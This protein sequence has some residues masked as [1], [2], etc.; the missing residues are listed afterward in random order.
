MPAIPNLPD[1][2]LEAMKREIEKRVNNQEPRDYLGASLIGNPCSRQIWYTIHHCEREPFT[3]DTLMKF[4]DGHRTEDLTAERL[5]MVDGLELWTHDEEGKQFGFVAMDGKFKGHVDGIIRGLLQAPSALHVW[6]AKACE[7]KKYNEFIKCKATY[8]EKNALKAWN[9]NYYV[10]AQIN[11]HYFQIDRH[12]LTV[13]RAGG[14]GYESC[15]TEYDGEF[16]ERFINRA[17]AIL[18]ANEPPPRISEKPE[19]Y[20]CNWCEFKGVCR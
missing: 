15:R 10:Q 4:D 17:D 13:A 8:G 20:I 18:Q 6:E 19:Y 7:D 12:Y 16:A 5:R 3:A 2:T 11:M 1:P 9:E 14:R